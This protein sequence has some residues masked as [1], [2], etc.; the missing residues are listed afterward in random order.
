[1]MNNPLAVISGR[2]QLLAMSLP[3]G[4]KEQQSA[5]QIVRES[6]R[7]S[8]L[9]TG[10]H[11][12]AE[13]PQPDRKPV[14]PGKLI[15]RVVGELRQARGKRR[16][17]PE[18]TLQIRDAP[19]AMLLDTEQISRSLTELLLNAVQ[20]NPKTM[21]AVSVYTKPSGPRDT[22]ALVI[23]VRDDGD[24][25][26]AHTLAHATDPFFSAKPAGRQVGLGLSRAQ[27][28]VQA[29]SGGLDLGSEPGHG[30]TATVWLPIGAMV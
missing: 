13:P 5:E 7:L 30:C 27:Q 16:D 21:V 4:S 1:E 15:H 3:P 25:M 22:P 11:L 2:S 14:D 18:I 29:H 19:Q 20:A 28:L 24:G 6:H 12:F 26:D 23:E 8:D 17:P 10:L 9:I